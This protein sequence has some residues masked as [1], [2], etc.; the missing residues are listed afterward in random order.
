M[1][2]HRLAPLLF[3]CTASLA[4][5]GLPLETPKPMGVRLADFVET[6]AAGDRF[7]VRPPVRLRKGA[8]G[9][10]VV[11]KVDPSDLRQTIEGIGGAMTESSAYVLAQLPAPSMEAAS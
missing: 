7:R 8:P 10:G 2:F 4:A 9:K 5:A 11:V 6:S 1:S 3:S